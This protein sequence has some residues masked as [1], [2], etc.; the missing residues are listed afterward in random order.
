MARRE[1]DGAQ[2]SRQG[3]RTHDVDRGIAVPL[4]SSESGKEA[5]GEEGANSKQVVP[6]CYRKG[7]FQAPRGTRGTSGT[8]RKKECS[9]S[10]PVKEN[11]V[12]DVA[13]AKAIQ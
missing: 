1:R 9:M 6:P 13:K 3:E 11:L 10:W 2:R 7:Y 12:K 8:L 5:S 4:R